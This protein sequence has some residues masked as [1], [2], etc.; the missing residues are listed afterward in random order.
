MAQPKRQFTR[1]F[2]LEAVR[3]A[4]AGDKPL[5]G[6]DSDQIAMLRLLLSERLAMNSFSL[7]LHWHIWKL[8]RYP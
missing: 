1:E 8:E 2:K 6:L 3:L 5:F 4:T 7:N